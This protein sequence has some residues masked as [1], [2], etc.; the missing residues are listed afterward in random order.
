MIPTDW[1]LVKLQD[2][3]LSIIDGDRGN[4]YPKSDDFTDNGYCLFLSAK[5]ITKNG[6]NINNYFFFTCINIS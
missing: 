2:T 4:N 6:F 1:E 3:S 5:N